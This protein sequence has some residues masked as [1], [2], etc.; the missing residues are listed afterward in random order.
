LVKKAAVDPNQD[1]RNDVAELH[2]VVAALDSNVIRLASAVGDM[3]KAMAIL[4]AMEKRLLDVEEKIERK[5]A[6]PVRAAFA[7]AGGVT[8]LTAG[9]AVL[10]ITGVLP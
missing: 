5:L 4:A 8:V 3:T 1:L 10:H 2:G 6:W 9:Y 7:W